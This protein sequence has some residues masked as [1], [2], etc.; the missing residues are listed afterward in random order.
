MKVLLLTFCM[1]YFN[2]CS[3]NSDQSTNYIYGSWDW[4][5]TSGGISGKEKSTPE[6]EGSSQ[7]LLFHENG[8]AEFY[9]DETLMEGVPFHIEKGK[10]IYSEENA[11]L[12]IYKGYRGVF[13]ITYLSK[14]T[15]ILGDNNYD[16]FSSTYTR[17]K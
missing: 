4:L 12:I 3:T 1:I 8:I 16:G 9:Q 15:L 5:E 6:T 10:S 7:R 2:G 13:V 17:T 11:D 14:D